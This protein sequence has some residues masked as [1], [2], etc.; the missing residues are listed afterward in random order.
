MRV[1]AWDDPVVIDLAGV[2]RPDRKVPVLKDHD[3]MQIVGHTTKVEVLGKSIRVSG[4]VSGRGEAAEQVTAMGKNEFPWQ[5]SVGLSVSKTENVG[6]GEHAIVNGRRIDGPATIARKSTFREISFTVWGADSTTSATVTAQSIEGSEMN[7]EQYLAAMGIDASTATVE[8]LDF[9]KKQ[10][11]K[12]NAKEDPKAE[13]KADN[14]PAK[15]MTATEVVESPEDVVSVMRAAAVAESKRIA[16]IQ[17]KFSEFADLAV[18]AMDEG[19]DD[20]R[21][22]AELR[23]A[24]AEKLA[25]GRPGGDI[26][27]SNFHV[28]SAPQ[29]QQ[30][31][32][33]AALAIGCDMD[34]EYLTKPFEA[35]K[36][37]SDRRL[38]ANLVKPISEKS[39]EYAA[40]HYSGFGLK[41]LCLWAARQEGRYDG[42][43]AN[44]AAIKASFSTTLIPTVFQNT[45]NRALLMA[46]QA[47]PLLWP[48]LARASSARDFRPITRF[49]VHGSGRWEKIGEGGKIKHGMLGEGT[50]YTNRLSTDAQMLTLTR[51]DLRNDDLGALTD[52]SQMMARYGSLAPEIGMFEAFLASVGS[53]FHTNNSNVI[54]GGT[55]VFGPDGLKA[56][57]TLFIK[58]KEDRTLKDKR[59]NKVAPFISVEPEI[60]LVP[61]ELYVSAFELTNSSVLQSGGT[62]RQPTSNFFANRFRVLQSPFLSDTGVHANASGTAFYL[63]ANPNMTEAINMLFLD[64]NQRPTVQSVS[65]DAD[66]LGI[67][68]RGYID[69]GV[70]MVEPAASARSAGA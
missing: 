38:F 55:S 57:Y 1:N 65:L 21:Q 13:K 45:M 40:K 15:K 20:G 2:E 70:A 14:T 67:G 4:V 48:Q 25:V 5:A 61:P 29:N 3:S 49:R 37:S 62:T 60:L 27:A 32:I 33:E 26:S 16:A 30:E 39:L 42:F 64:G 54:T 59:D 35:V 44:E 9:A 19:W 36:H 52:I 31:V 41:D 8:Q 50:K 68:F 66:E 56:L 18:K 17:A 28:K 24:K 58:R 53:F 46:Y 47:I 69:Y 63:M 51:E 43:T 23:A 6:P 22:E 10:F 7:W 11:E 34:P 12:M